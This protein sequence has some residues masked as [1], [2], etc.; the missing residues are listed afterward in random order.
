LNT[1]KKD[2]HLPG[3]SVVI[4]VFNGGADLQRCLEAVSASSYPILE[5]I[6]VDDASTDAMVKP[7]AE[8]Y[9]A[10]VI[11]LDQQCGPAKARNRGVA[12][13]RGDIIFFTDA[14]VLLHPDAI[15]KAVKALQAESKT[16][17]VFGSYD[18][19]PA[20]ASFISQ[21]R[22][23]FHHWVHQ[24]GAED[25]STFWTG[26]GAIRKDV[27]E[28]MG[29]FNQDFKRPSIE[30]IELG[31]RLR[32]S[33]YKI[34]LLKNMFGKH[35]KQWRFLNMVR[36]DIFLRGVPWMRVVLRDGSLTSDLNLSYKSRLATLFAGLLGLLLPGLILTGHAAA[37]LPAAIFIL[38]AC[39]GARPPA[40]RGRRAATTLFTVA[41]TL[42]APL[43]VYL[44]LPDP[45][46][47][48]PLGLVLAIIATHLAFYSYLVH[49]R[50][51]V[52]ALAVAP[53]QIV[54]F[55][56]CAVSIPIAFIQ[57]HLG[58]QQSNAGS[59]GTVDNDR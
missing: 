47:L 10:H 39:I 34:R 50:S 27:Y 13:A 52:F 51:I 43:A 59:R 15:G 3:V 23:L 26:C 36:T 5:C 9:A 8:R 54:F 6:L 55:S 56:C 4:P 58:G 49:K 20:D 46:A 30:D 19:Q 28:E 14:D 24:T 22:N 11:R 18:D 45:L 41:L 53:M 17:A 38:S 35:L 42:L 40:K 31:A 44:L 7:A 32:R 33:G 16:V 57:H 21:Y 29:G 37:I 2:Q 1:H 12:E 48:L 25:A